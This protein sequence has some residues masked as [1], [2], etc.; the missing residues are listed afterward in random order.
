M[1]LSLTFIL[2]SSLRICQ[3][4][5]KPIWFPRVFAGKALKMLFQGSQSA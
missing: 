2:D 5:Q 3:F 1:E 4:P